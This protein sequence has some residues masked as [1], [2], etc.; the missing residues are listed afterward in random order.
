[1]TRS[2]LQLKPDTSP[3]EEL[4]NAVGPVPNARLPVK[5]VSNTSYDPVTL[6]KVPKDGWM[7]PPLAA[8]VKK[9]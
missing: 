7:A 8:F 1:M 4:T 5:L 2:K 6:V 3:E 9:L